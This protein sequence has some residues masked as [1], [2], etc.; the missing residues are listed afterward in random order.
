LNI[1]LVNLKT[2]VAYASKSGTTEQTAQIIAETLRETIGLEV[3]LVNVRKDKTNISQYDNIVIGAGVRA[4][5]V[6]GE[7]SDL[8]KQDFGSKKIAFFVCCGG[9]GDPA[10]YDESCN[11]YLKGVLAKYPNLKTVATETF[12]GRMKMLGKQLFDNVDPAKIRT[13]AEKLGSELTK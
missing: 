8:L 3:E 10:K 9:A 12:G 5:K 4:G 11:K 13:W 1:R 6:Y 7:V 2:L